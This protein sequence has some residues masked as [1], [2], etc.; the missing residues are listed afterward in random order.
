MTYT[1]LHSGS[2]VRKILANHGGAMCTLLIFACLP[3]M[4]IPVPLADLAESPTTD[5]ERQA[6]ETLQCQ[7]RGV[8]G[9]L[10]R[11]RITRHP[12]MLTCHPALSFLLTDS[13]F[14]GALPT[15]AWLLCQVDDAAIAISSMYAYLCR[16]QC[17]T[18]L[19]LLG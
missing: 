1:A 16:P 12:H 19:S 8:S 13:N 7:Y 11:D 5:K 18:P 15:L 17:H 9:E 14:H 10:M 6:L 3:V 4:S 2:Y